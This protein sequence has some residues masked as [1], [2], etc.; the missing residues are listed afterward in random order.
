MLLSKL[1]LNLPTLLKEVI[2]TTYNPHFSLV[3]L[4]LAFLDVTCLRKYLFLSYPQITQKCH[5]SRREIENPVYIKIILIRL[6]PRAKSKILKKFQISCCKI[7]KKMTEL[8][9]STA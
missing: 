8:C 7:P 5:S 9:E 3:F 1:P 2:E 6:L 4:G